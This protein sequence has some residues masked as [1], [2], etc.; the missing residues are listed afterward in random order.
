MIK[1]VDLAL[2]YSGCVALRGISLHIQKQDF[3]FIVGSTGGGKSSV[4]KSA[5][6]Y[7]QPTNSSY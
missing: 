6:I 4:L 7:I 2:T 5:V 1:F 3:V